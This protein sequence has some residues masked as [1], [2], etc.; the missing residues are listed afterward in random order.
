MTPP[1]ESQGALR[2]RMIDRLVVV[3]AAV[4]LLG[5]LAIRSGNPLVIALGVCPV[6][7][8]AQLI[9][10][11][12]RVQVAPLVINALATV[13]PLLALAL[14]AW[15]PPGAML[16]VFGFIAAALISPLAAF[17]SA[18]IYGSHRLGSLPLALLS[19]GSAISGLL[20]PWVVGLPLA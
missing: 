15:T 2:D 10:S 16:W 5:P 7:G 1:A 9:G 20:L 18:T 14:V 11:R 12:S 19:V 4:T 17:V 13:P 6:L 8:A 3:G